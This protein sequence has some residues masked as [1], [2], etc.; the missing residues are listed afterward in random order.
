MEKVFKKIRKGKARS[1]PYPKRNIMEKKLPF[2][3]SLSRKVVLEYEAICDELGI[4][5]NVMGEELFLSFVRDYRASQKINLK[6][7]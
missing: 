5:R 7:K 1:L 2:V 4:D 3:L 6:I